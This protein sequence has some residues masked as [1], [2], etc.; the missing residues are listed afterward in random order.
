[1]I[2]LVHVTY[3]ASYGG[4]ANGIVNLCNGLDPSRFRASIIT[5][6]PNGGFEQTLAS[7]RVTLYRLL[8]SRG[9]D[10]SLILRLARL[11]RAVRPDVL[12]THAWG[13]LCEGLTAG[14]LAG[15]PMHVHGEH[16]TLETR[17][18]HRWV[19]RRVWGWLDQVVAVSEILRG[20]MANVIGY[21]PARIRVIPNGVDTEKFRSDPIGRARVRR[22]MMVSDED[23]VVGA[24]G[25]LHAIKGHRHLIQALS[26]LPDS[27]RLWLVG[28][29]PLRS[30]LEALA[31]SLGVANRTHFLGHRDDVPDILLGLDALCQPSLNEGMSNTILEAMASRLPV[32][33][34]AVGGNVETVVH[35]ETGLLVGPERPEALAGALQYL[36]FHREEAL[37]LG[38]A[39]RRRAVDRYSIRRMVRDYEE[40]YA[41][42]CRR[43]NQRRRA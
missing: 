23:F 14:K 34:T 15:I 1:M 29:G 4:T 43:N 30:E 5:F 24:V 32:V 22:E 7:D 39:G 42:L 27:V 9:N 31:S 20:S 36:G 28:D 41:N 8:P 6:T 17:R 26:L 33:A 16:G 38:E 12:H 37:R 13:T 2:R 35:G 19:Q 21:D 11:L 3:A 25:R 18:L 40:L 10:P